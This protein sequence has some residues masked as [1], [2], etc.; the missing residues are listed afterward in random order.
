[1]ATYDGLFRSVD[2][3]LSFGNN[4]PLY[5]NNNPLIAGKTWDL[6][7]DTATPTKV[8][9]CINGQGIFV[10]ID[11]GATFPT[12]LFGNPGAPA[13]GTYS[14]VTMTQSTQP[15]GKTLYASVADAGFA[16]L[17]LYKSIDTPAG[18]NS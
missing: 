15:D 8:Y 2:G 7:L 17:G 6:H 18:Q 13:A 14:C 4:A 10:S 16:Y 11:S 3:G 12:N 5:N 1:V 9:A